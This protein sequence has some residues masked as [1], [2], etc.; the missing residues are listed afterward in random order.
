MST[1]NNADTGVPASAHPDSLATSALSA[2]C[3]SEPFRDPVCN[4][5]IPLNEIRQ[6]KYAEIRFVADG[7]LGLLVDAVTLLQAHTKP[8]LY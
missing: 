7:G 8:R 5:I 4:R 3:V 2:R 6:N 1:D